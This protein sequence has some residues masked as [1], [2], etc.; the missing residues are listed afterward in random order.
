MSSSVR[1]SFCGDAHPIIPTRTPLLR[2]P[3][4]P[5]EFANLLLLHVVNHYLNVDTS[6]SDRKHLLSSE[7]YYYPY[8]ELNWNPYLLHFTTSSIFSIYYSTTTTYFNQKRVR[9]YLLYFLMCCTFSRFSFSLF[10]MD[11]EMITNVNNTVV[12]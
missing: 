6:K 4:S 10:T 11:F 9:H 1:P 2:P 3:A 5:P 7:D 12:C 8:F